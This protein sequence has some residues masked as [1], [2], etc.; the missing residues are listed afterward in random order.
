MKKVV[1]LILVV[2]SVE[3]N[4]QTINIA[5]I[6]KE[7]DSGSAKAQLQLG[8]YYQYDLRVPDYENAF[9]WYKKSALQNNKIAQYQL[10]VLYD[11][12]FGVPKDNFLALAWYSVAKHNNG[13]EGELFKMIQLVEKYSLYASPVT[14]SWFTSVGVIKTRSNDTPPKFVELNV[15]I[16]YE[17]DNQEKLIEMQK[18]I[19]QI[20]DLIRNYISMKSV[21]SLSPAN[22]AFLKI[23]LAYY[24]NDQV[25]GSQVVDE[26]LFQQL[27]I[28]KD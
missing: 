12:G 4:S 19:Y 18:R 9:Q 23:E 26:I 11:N 22:E 5:N 20:R 25:F 15:I 1:Q 17:I 21:E 8:I 27:D 14:K 28:L 2:L 7:A 3:V 6:F 24:L 16:G 10:G 13:N